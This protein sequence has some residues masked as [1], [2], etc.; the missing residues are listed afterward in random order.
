EF[1]PGMLLAGLSLGAWVGIKTVAR[2]PKLDT[3]RSA[4]ATLTVNDLCIL[5]PYENS[6]LVMSMNG[7]QVKEVLERGYRNCRWYK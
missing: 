4:S 1:T 2:V 3:S 6:L 7:P 5:M